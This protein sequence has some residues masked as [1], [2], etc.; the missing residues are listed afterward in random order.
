MMG[1]LGEGGGLHAGRGVGSVKGWVRGWVV[2]EGG[3]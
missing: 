2:L 3:L 1:G